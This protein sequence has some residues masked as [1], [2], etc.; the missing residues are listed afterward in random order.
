M[1]SGAGGAF[2][3]Y[4]RLVVGGTVYQPSTIS[5]TTNSGQSVIT[6][7]GTAAG[8]TVSRETQASAEVEIFLLDAQSISST[9][10]QPPITAKA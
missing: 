4:G 2:T 5:S 6:A 8:L 3:A 7:S 1:I 10:A 9:D